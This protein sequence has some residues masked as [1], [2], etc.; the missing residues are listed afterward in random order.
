MTNDEQH[1]FNQLVEVPLLNHYLN[2]FS[3]TVELVREF[4]RVFGKEKVHNVIS[5][6]FGKIALDNTKK[7]I[8]REG[9]EIGSL[10]DFRCYFNN[11]MKLPEVNATHTMEMRN[12]SK[13]D[14]EYCATECIY[15]SAFRELDAGDLGL[16]M[17]CNHDFQSA[18]EYN[19]KLRL[20]RDKTLMAGDNCCNYS[21]CWEE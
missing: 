10:Q 1:K 17:I 7:L 21:Y 13:N 2:M 15:A 5:N 6:Y 4:E 20:A 19:P 12:D 9:L 11:M 8:K 14:V 18:R 3:Q 16:L